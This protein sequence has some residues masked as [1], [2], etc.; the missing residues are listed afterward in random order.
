MHGNNFPTVLLL[1]SSEGYFGAENMLV[2]LGVSLLK[3]GCRCVVGVFCDTRFRHTEVGDRAQAQG[4]TVEIVPCVGRFDWRAVAHIK[5]LVGKYEVDVLHTHGYKADLYGCA[6]AWPGRVALV[7]TCHNWPS[8]SRSMRA[9]AALDRFAM[10]AFDRVVAISDPLM[11]IL[12]RSGIQVAKLDMIANGVETERF[13]DARAT[14]RDVAD[15]DDAP[16]I[17][18]V[19]RLVP[20]KGGDILLRAAQRVLHSHPKAK[21]VIVGDG[22]SRQE[23]ELLASQL[24]ISDRVV[25]AG[26]RQD[27][28]GVYASL[29]LVVLPSLDEAMPMCVLEA[30]AAGK[31]VVATRVGAV[32]KLVDPNRTGVLVEPGDVD[33]LSAA[34]LEVLD[35]P[36]WARHLGENGRARVTE[37]FSAGSMARRYV[38]LYREVADVRMRTTANVL[39]RSA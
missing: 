22:P 25:F 23:W 15:G 20:A 3:L 10:R 12:E 21:L 14:L 30:M 32:P 8:R 4:L 24:D 9:Y 36:E 34:I 5:R 16:L 35:N 6:A 1:I 29:Q 11:E 37:H 39:R 19:G 2:N 26:V 31:P 27:M 28:P 7:A 33:G 13:C 17:G 18:F 38:E